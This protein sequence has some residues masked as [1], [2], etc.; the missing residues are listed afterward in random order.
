MRQ[1]ETRSK[2][3]GE[4]W[5]SRSKGSKLQWWP[6][7]QEGE[8]RWENGCEGPILCQAIC[9]VNG[10]EDGWEVDLVGEELS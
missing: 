3:T 2:E 1:E 7:E 10:W 8:E 9:R 6:R 5:E 4:R